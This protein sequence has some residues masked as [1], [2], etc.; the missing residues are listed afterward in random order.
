MGIGWK[1]LCKAQPIVRVRIKVTVRFERKSALAGMCLQ[2]DCQGKTQA[3]R[4]RLLQ[5]ISS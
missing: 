3:V 5:E 2:S 1:G 4:R